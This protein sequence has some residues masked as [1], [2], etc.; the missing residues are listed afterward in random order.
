MLWLLGKLLLPLAALAVVPLIIAL[1]FGESQFALHCAEVALAFA[2]AGWLLARIEAA[3]DVRP[4]EA[5]TV[6]ALVFLIAAAG[7]TW[8]FAGAGLDPLDA[9]FESV[10]AI[11]TTGL[12]TLEDI[13]GRSPAFQFMRAWMQWYGGLAI[14]V[15]ALALV[16][17]PGVAARRL[18][19]TE[20]EVTDI[21]G[22]TRTR[23][24]QALVV[25]VL[26]TT[27]AFAALLLAGVDP[28][29]AIT[30]ALAAVS[31]GGFS[32]HNDSLAGLGGL[33]V[34][35]TVSVVSFAGAISLMFYVRGWQGRWGAI[36]KDPDLLAVVLAC[37]ASAML[38]GLCMAIIGGRP[39][40]EV[41]RHAP[42]IAVSAQTTT[43][44]STLD[45]G[46]LDSGSKLVLAASMFVGGDAGSTAGGI[47]IGRVLV[48]LA[49]VRLVILRTRMPAHA[50]VEPRISGRRLNSPEV[51]A[52]L[53]VVCL[54]VMVIG[55]SWL[56]F[57]TAG[58]DPMNALFE[59]ASAVGTVG[60]STGIAN[61]DLAPG[62][63][64]LLT[65]D[66]MM[67]RLE[68]VAFIL[69]LY[70]PTWLGRRAEVS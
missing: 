27:L 57:V 16:L 39:W 5:M 69:L 11:T 24:R 67:G 48:L 21:V 35:I 58:Y 20:T 26:L 60:L 34:Q 33:A 44:F 49:L 40:A 46:A 2:V 62:L 42:L 66:M 25:Y 45:V 54:H 38:V 30:H 43:G 12:T 32:S 55:S 14:V 19:G 28:F 52:A 17:E 65:A 50:V 23:A 51:Y 18:A 3:S 63:K 4:N 56:I 59:V 31:T 22:G 68:V 1:T 47:K 15:L 36:I 6:T 10:S 70:P 41:M 37:V 8:P 61:P 64:V 7:M 29:D 53:A 13:E 9:W